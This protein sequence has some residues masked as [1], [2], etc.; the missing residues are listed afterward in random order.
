MIITGG[1][2]DY[3]SGPYTVTFL[4]GQTNISFSVPINDDNILEK[5][6]AFNLIISPTSLSSRINIGAQS[7]ATITIVGND[8]K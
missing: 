4:A 8:R 1:G 2:V 6:E 5:D 3:D 7:Q